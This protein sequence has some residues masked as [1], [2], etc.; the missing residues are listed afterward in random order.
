MMTTLPVLLLILGVNSPDR[1]MSFTRL[2]AKPGAVGEVV[3]GTGKVLTFLGRSASI[4]SG[5]KSQACLQ[6]PEQPPGRE[7]R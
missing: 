6:R 5:K 1:F 2:G 4:W 7:G 3:G